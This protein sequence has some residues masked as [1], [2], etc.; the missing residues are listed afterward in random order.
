MCRVVQ[1]Y[2]DRCR[3]IVCCLLPIAR[4]CS[5]DAYLHRHPIAD[6][7]FIAC[8]SLYGHKQILCGL[9]R[10]LCGFLQVYELS[11]RQIAVR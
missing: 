9:L 5:A 4:Y 10:D 8:C 11:L 7:I 6:C 1:V 3:T 2:A